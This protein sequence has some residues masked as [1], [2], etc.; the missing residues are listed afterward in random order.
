MASTHPQDPLADRT[1]VAVVNTS[2]EIAELIQF[3]LQHEGIR[4]VVAYSTDF[5]RGRQDHAGFLRWYDPPVV[6]WDIALPYAETWAFFEQVRTSAAGQGRT[7]V[8]TTANKQALETFVG[9]TP[10]LEIMGKPY[11]IDQLVEAVRRG[12]GGSDATQ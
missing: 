8:L 11:D 7:V 6:V 9:E 1:L 10:A 5:K 2:E 4:T 12:I 3:V